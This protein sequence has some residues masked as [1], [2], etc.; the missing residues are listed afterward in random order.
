MKFFSLKQIIFAAI[1]SAAMVAVSLVAVPLVVALP[2]P[3]IRN[4]VVAPFFGL[5]LALALIRLQHAATATLISLFT[6]AVQ[7][8]IGPVILVFL[9]AS[10]VTTDLVRFLIWRGSNTRRAVILSAG[11]YMAVMVPFGA[12][13]GILMA[14]DTPIADLLKA[15]WFILGAAALSFGLGAG[16]AWLGVKIASEF[17]NIFLAK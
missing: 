16:G 8:F 2:I 7:V 13:F 9:L 15:P 14:G 10:G 5:L 11:I 17:K 4:L 12:F 6:G 1:I 3:G